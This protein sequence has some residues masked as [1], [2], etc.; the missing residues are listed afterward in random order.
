VS[1][2]DAKSRDSLYGGP[3]NVLLRPSLA[4][5]H[6]PG[7]FVN[8]SP[9]IPPPRGGPDPVPDA[10]GSRALRL[11]LGGAFDRFPK[12]TVVLEHPGETRLYLIGSGP[13]PR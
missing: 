9:L 8:S 4:F 2:A 1:E 10:I 5:N 12:L 11:V 7:R 6:Q 3:E 13:A